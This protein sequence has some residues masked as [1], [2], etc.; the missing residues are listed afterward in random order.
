MSKSNVVILGGGG[1]GAHIARALSAKLDHSRFNLVLVTLADRYVHMPALVRMLVDTPDTKYLE[2]NA[3]VPYDTLFIGGKGTVKI[4]KVV[5]IEKGQGQGGVLKLEDG[6]TVPFAYLVVATGSKWEGPLKELNVSNTEVF[7]ASLKSW[8][9]TF[10]K[11]N[12]IVIVG[13]G[14]VGLGMVSFSCSEWRV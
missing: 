14:A 12:D 3:L 9:E 2:E 5:E 4:G 1:S 7:K 8:R 13:A 6:E 10:A 11:A